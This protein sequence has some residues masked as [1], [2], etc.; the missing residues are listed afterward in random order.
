M[1]IIVNIVETLQTS[2]FVNTAHPNIPMWRTIHH[3]WK[4]SIRFINNAQRRAAQ[5]QLHQ[6]RARSIV[7][8]DMLDLCSALISFGIDWLRSMNSDLLAALA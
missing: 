3:A 5:V 7:V 6:W 1:I 8:V 2:N 4:M